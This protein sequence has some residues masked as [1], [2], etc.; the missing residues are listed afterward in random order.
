MAAIPK[1][2]G[3]EIGFALHLQTASES[4]ELHPHIHCLIPAGGLSFDGES[5]GALPEM[6]LCLH[7]FSPAFRKLLLNGRGG[8]F[9][10]L[11]FSDCLKQLRC[12]HVFDGYMNKA[13]RRD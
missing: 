6:A 5:R 9:R 11:E 7:A 8:A 1:Y 12:F 4:I 2:L 10:N 3:A 13:R